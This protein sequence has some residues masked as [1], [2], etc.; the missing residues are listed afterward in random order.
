MAEV[1]QNQEQGEE[2]KSSKKW[3]IIAA[4]ALLLLGGGG[5]GY[6]FFMAGD[7]GD[8]AAEQGE[9]GEEGSEQA[10]DKPSFYYDM[11]KPLI[12]N[13]PQGSAARLVQVSISI[14]VKDEPTVEALKK[15][16]PMI[17]NNLLMLISAHDPGELQSVAG[18]EILRGKM[19]KEISKV[20]QKM[21]ESDQV[22]ELF[23]TS[24][25]M[26]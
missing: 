5:A 1:E 26:Q 15:H 14:M 21:T 22:Q 6:Y 12:V 16:E 23:F 17:R 10:V 3:L 9:D 20:M 18:K 2:P 8:D 11:T 13:Y 24:F 25:V 7:P 4:I 19:L